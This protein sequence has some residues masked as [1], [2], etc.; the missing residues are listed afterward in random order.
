[1]ELLPARLCWW[2]RDSRM[3][4]N[5][6]RCLKK[7][8]LGY[9]LFLEHPDYGFAWK[10]WEKVDLWLWWDKSRERSHS[11]VNYLGFADYFHFFQW[12]S[13]LAGIMLSHFLRQWLVLSRAAK[14]LGCSIS[15]LQGLDGNLDGKWNFCS[16]TP[17]PQ[18]F[19]P[20]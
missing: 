4:F 15:F 10:Q 13:I 17:G 20:S 12:G 18:G 1:M 16:S 7:E 9:S 14:N 19:L 5:S 6:C 3:D 8:K 2:K 11:K